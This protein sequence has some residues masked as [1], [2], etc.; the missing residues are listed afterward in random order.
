MADR[1]VCVIGCSVVGL[2]T[3]VVLAGLGHRVRLFESDKLRRSI[4]SRGEVPFYEPGLSTMLAKGIRARRISVEGDLEKTVDSSDFT[5]LAV[6][7]PLLKS[8]SPN[9][10]RLRDAA[11]SI[12]GSLRKGGIVVQR[13]AAPPGTAE[14]LLV[15]AL[16]SQS[17][18]RAERDFGVAVNPV[19]FSMGTAVRDSLK[20]SRIVVG[21]DTRK[22][23][24]EVMDLYDRLDAPKLL[25]NLGTAEMIKVVSDCFLAAKASLTNEV[26]GLC[27]R[28]GVDA[29]EVM[30][31]VRLDPRIG[32]GYTRPSL[33]FGG[34]GLPKNL[35]ITISKAE[36]MGLK[37]EI[38]RAVR[39]ANDRQP[40]RA[41][42]IL[43]D[44]LGNL[45][46]KRIALLGLAFKAGVDD[47][48]ESRA[49]P[50]AVELLARG[51]TIVGYD[52]LAKASFI[53]ALPGIFYASSVQEALLE[54]D[55]CVIQTEEEEFSKLGKSDFDLMG[56]RL[57]VDGT[58]VL[59]PAKLK[60]YGVTLRAVGLGTRLKAK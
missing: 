5:F 14:E 55:G 8:S 42:Q 34:C 39:R 57:V 38:L 46:G 58:R 23:A 35:S 54:A 60:K 50:I 59:P 25:T 1:K 13:T 7:I 37:P 18:L 31:G 4:I 40:M 10:S 51:A 12:G 19:F 24:G 33:G 26:A 32:E 27:E 47:I 22:T 3:G 52:P 29:E 43:E 15:P 16:E 44:E 17:G 30:E 48:T 53:R 11:R 45:R 21:G 36:S 49:F 2:T 41:V 6:P 56:N 20:P 28:L 9:I